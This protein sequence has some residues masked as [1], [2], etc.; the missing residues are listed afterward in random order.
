LKLNYMEGLSSS[1][2]KAVH[3]IA[4]LLGLLLFFPGLAPAEIP[5]RVITLGPS[6]SHTIAA[7]GETDRLVGRCSYSTEPQEVAV[8]PSVGGLADPNLEM[9]LSLRPDLVLALEFL[10][11]GT[12]QRLENTGITV[13]RLNY[14]TLEEVLESTRTIGRALGPEAQQKAVELTETWLKNLRQVRE[15]IAAQPMQ[16]AEVPVLLTFGVDE[17]T[18]AGEGTYLDE[19]LAAA[20]GDNIAADAESSW[21]KLN[22]EAVLARNPAV[23]IFVLAPEEFQTLRGRLAAL[24]QDPFWG[25]LEAVQTGRVY[26]LTKDLPAIPGPRIPRALHALAGILRPE[27]FPEHLQSA[28]EQGT[29][30]EAMKT[31]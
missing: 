24:A 17:I 10:P 11:V 20:G 16:S 22:R 30:A 5:Q 21:P 12:Q 18:S 19:L 6:I 3:K 7:L 28:R 26:W 14:S 1:W 23:I 25:S 8:I 2:R 27:V 4:G 9:V 15:R 13:H 29:V 31:P